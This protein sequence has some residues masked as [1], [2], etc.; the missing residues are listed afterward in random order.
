VRTFAGGLLSTC[1]LASTGAPS[2]A[3][4]EH[5]PLHGRIGHIPAEN[6]RWALV[7]DSGELAVEV[8]GDVVEAALGQPT[9][10]LRRRIV[11]GVTEPWLRIE[12]TVQNTSWR[13]AGHMFRHH[14]NLGAPIVVPG[15]VVTATADVVG[16]RDRPGPA[17]V[18][19]PWLLHVAEGP[20]PE[21]VAYCRP[22]PGPSVRVE[23]RAPEGL[24]LSI[25]Q[26]TQTWNQ[27]VLWRDPTP[28]VNVL[29]VEPSTSRDSGRAQAEQDGEIIWLE[30][31]ESRSYRS[32]V[33][34]GR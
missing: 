33:R 26:D 8:T 13:R 29:G 16:E 18:T 23:V 17:S 6:V 20:A 21:V 12:D 19:L 14:F 4:G 34:A 22:H 27:V 32:E 28:G 30:P 11:A 3:G 24:W 9:L 7:E 5:H 31:G 10:V 25:E 2:T 1:G 15:S